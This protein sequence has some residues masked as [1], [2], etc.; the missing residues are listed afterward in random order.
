V[1]WFDCGFLPTRAYLNRTLTF[2]RVGVVNCYTESTM[3]YLQ[4]Y[5]GGSI[6]F[7]RAIHHPTLCPSFDAFLA[8]LLHLPRPVAAP[9]AQ[10]LQQVG[11][12]IVW[13]LRV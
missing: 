5:K 3:G 7:D 10:M 8:A 4:G 9:G 13:V 12:M 2:K 11:V 1:A 6:R